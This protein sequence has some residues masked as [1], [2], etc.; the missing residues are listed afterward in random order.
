MSGASARGLSTAGSRSSRTSDRMDQSGLN[1]VAAMISSTG[2]SDVAGADDDPSARRGDAIDAEAGDQLEP[3]VS[4]RRARASP[5]LP[6]SSSWSL[7]ASRRATARAPAGESPRECS[8]PAP[9]PRAGPGRATRSAPSGRCRR[10]A[11]GGPRTCRTAAEHVGDAVEDCRRGR[12]RRAPE[13]PRRRA[14]RLLDGAGGVDDRPREHVLFA[15]GP[16]PGR[17]TAPPATASF[18]RS[19]PCRVTAMTRVLRRMCG[20][21]SRRRDKG[22]STARRDRCRSGTRRRPASYQPC[23]ARIAAA[24][25]STLNFHGENIRTCPHRRMPAPTERRPRARAGSGRGTARGRRR[26]GRPGRRR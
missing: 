7:R 21:S 19:W 3:A 24:A 15:V 9:R 1:P 10:P 14:R 11:P 25:E 4:S 12:A 18:I 6:R 16:R 8:S 17:R 23:R 13:G 2:A 26:P 20:R 22:S 5:S